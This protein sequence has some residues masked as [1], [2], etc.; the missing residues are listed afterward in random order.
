MKTLAE[1]KRQANSG[2]MKLE[3]IER[4]G[5]T[6]DNIPQRL[7]GIRKVKKANSIGLILENLD[8]K[9]SKLRIER[10]KLMDY[11]GKTLIIYEPGEREP[12]EQE[13][14]VLNEWRKIQEEWIKQN[15][16]NDT[17]WKKFHILKIVIILIYLVLMNV[18]V[19]YI[20]I[21]E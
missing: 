7:R 16:Y 14:R 19:N 17:Y 10:A 21:M 1:L 20:S 3:L 6:N 18:K 2:K 13:Q 4:Y 9:E 15:P 11:D 8:G 12:N 5:E